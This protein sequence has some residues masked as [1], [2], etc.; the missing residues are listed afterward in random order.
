[1]R[2]RAN[3]DNEFWP[4]IPG[5]ISAEE[6]VSQFKQPP[7]IRRRHSGLDPESSSFSDCYPAGCRIGS[8][9]TLRN[10]REERL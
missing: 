3:Q 8:G 4:V 6:T 9:M 5:L 1:M 10:L 7:L 2:F